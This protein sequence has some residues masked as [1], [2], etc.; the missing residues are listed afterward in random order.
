MH[1][2]AVGKST[3]SLFITKN[4]KVEPR[5]PKLDGTKLS[6]PLSVITDPQNPQMVTHEKQIKYLGEPKWI[7]TKAQ[8]SNYRNIVFIL[9]STQGI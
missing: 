7:L 2:L 3:K 9:S 5:Y 4:V 6:V 1:F 8:S